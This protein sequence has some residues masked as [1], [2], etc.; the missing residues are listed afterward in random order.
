MKNRSRQR[1]NRRKKEERL[2][3]RNC[4]GALD[5]TPYQAVLAMR[6]SHFFTPKRKEV[7]RHGA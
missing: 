6:Y 3:I 2:D 7:E 4:T 5:P 1:E